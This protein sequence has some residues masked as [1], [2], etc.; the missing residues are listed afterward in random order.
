M[1]LSSSGDEFCKKTDRAIEGLTKTHKLVDDCLI[2]GDSEEECIKNVEEFLKRCEEFNISISRKKLQFGR[3]V[4]F[5]GWVVDA[6]EGAPP[7]IIPC[8]DRLAAIRDFPEPK[9][10]KNLREFMGLLNQISDWAPDRA[11][12]VP[13]LAA[14]LSTKVEYFMTPEAREEFEKGKK[15]LTKPESNILYPFTPGLP[16]FVLPDASCLFG[17]G[18]LVLQQRLNDPKKWN[19]IQCGSCTLKPSQKRYAPVELESLAIHFALKK[20]AYYLEG[21][22]NFTVLSDHKPLEGLFNNKE[23]RDIDNPRIQKIREKLMKFSFRVQYT[24]GKLHFAADALSRNPLFKPMSKE[25]DPIDDLQKTRRTYTKYQHQYAREDPKLR[26]MF[27]S[28]K[29]KDYQQVVEAIRQHKDIKKLPKDHP[30]REYEKFQDK[31]SI[32]DSKENPLMVFNGSRIIVP[33]SERKNVLKKLH[34][35][36]DMTKK[37]LSKAK[38]RYFWCKM[39]ADVK[40]MCESCEACQ[41]EGQ[42]QWRESMTN[43][44]RTPLSELEAMEEVGVDLAD[45]GGKTYLVMS[46]RYSGYPFC[47]QIRNSTT[48]TVTEALENWFLDMGYPRKIRCDFGPA[49]RQRFG[50][51]CSEK[52][53]IWQ[54][55]SAYNSRSAGLAEAGVKRIKNCIKKA[56]E[57]KEDVKVALSE[58][59]LSPMDDLEASPAEIFF[60][61]QMR[62]QLA[63]LKRDIKIKES[64]EKREEKRNGYVKLPGTKKRKSKTLKVNEKVVVQHHKSKKWNIHGKVKEVVNMGR[65]Y[66]IET[67][68]GSEYLRNRK[69]VKLDKTDDSQKRGSPSNETCS[70]SAAGGKQASSKEK[71]AATPTAPRHSPRLAARER[72][73]QFK[74]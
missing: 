38:H 6:E 28:A 31:I 53:I 72:R 3:R 44:S 34:L 39:A 48:Q 45:L 27:E 5:G 23:I 4:R 11:Q 63:G 22:D 57:A 16:V 2:E 21:L 65:S 25:D 36:H 7:K 54:R 15:E 29:D 1:G 18:F 50:E 64:V 40:K 19:I 26:N 8:P 59:R 51:Y 41:Q 35:S 12:H 13:Q 9:T 24:K 70:E 66:I 42:C 68:D 61:R 37:T 71:H 47:T 55:S 73:V 20:A 62:G 60:G 33:E 56:T 69:F 14:L 49:F 10:R 17:L 52:G 67:N 74:E 32:I 46:D 30:A 43:E 58:M